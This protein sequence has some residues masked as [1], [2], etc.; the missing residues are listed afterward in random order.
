DGVV[1]S[2]QEIERVKQAVGKNFLV[3]SPGI[4][5]VWAAAQDQKRILTPAQA[6]QK[7]ADFL[8]IGRPVI[9]DPS[10]PNAFDRII[11]EI[12]A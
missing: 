2:P 1:C 7:G 12:S 8:V 9:A 6:I 5:P 4:R 3:V 11:R 10:P